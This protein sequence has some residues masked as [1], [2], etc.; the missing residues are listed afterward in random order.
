MFNT[1]EIINEESEYSTN[2]EVVILVQVVDF[3]KVSSSEKFWMAYATLF[4][5]EGFSSRNTDKI[6]RE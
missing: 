2:F 6:Y 3:G 1:S 4:E 5:C